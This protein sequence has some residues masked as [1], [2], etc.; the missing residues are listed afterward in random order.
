[1]YERFRLLAKTAAVMG[2]S[3]R[4]QAEG[5]VTHV[6]VQELWELELGAAVPAAGSRDFH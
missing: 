4:V 6:I 2:V 5:G 1:V 3:G